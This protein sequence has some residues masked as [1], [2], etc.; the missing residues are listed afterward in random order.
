MLHPRILRALEDKIARPLTHIFLIIQCKQE[1]Y[2]RL[3]ISK[4]ACYSH[5]KKQ[6]RTWKLQ[7]YYFYFCSLQGHGEIS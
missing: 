6:A 1:L 2:L 4:R 3:Q 5:E 7:T